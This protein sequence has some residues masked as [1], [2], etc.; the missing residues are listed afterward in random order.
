MDILELLKQDEEAIVAE[1]LTAVRWLE[2]Y[3][4]D[5]EALCRERLRALVRLVADAIRA[6]DLG[7]LLEHAGQIARDRHASGYDRAEVTGAFSAVEDA[8][9]H[10]TSQVLPPEARGWALSLVGTA[11]AHA[12][13][14]L[15]SAFA[16]AGSSGTP[17]FVDL[18]PIFVRAGERRTRHD[19]DLVA[20][21]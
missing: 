3:G 15:A 18:S 19:D 13:K 8:I 9:W 6:R 2:H 16:E 5:G 10:R 12:R 7:D 4:R 1:A 14:A 17:A 21:L 20:P 11:L